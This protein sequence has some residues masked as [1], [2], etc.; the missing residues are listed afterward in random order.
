KFLADPERYLSDAPRPEPE[1]TPGAM[2]TCPMHPQIR[3]EGPGTCPI[4]GMALEPEE[5]TLD[6]K[7]NPE[8]VDFTRRLWVS[9]VL[10]VPLLAVSMG[11]EMLGLQLV[12]PTASP[13]VQLALTT[14]IVLWGG[15][16]FF[17]RGWASLKSRHY[18]MFTLIAIG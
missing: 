4:C 1:A 12:S 5:S 8:L 10:T 18:N 6:D 17:E 11:A 15:L 13:W 9:A 7:P 16:P 3:Q 14:P 2:W